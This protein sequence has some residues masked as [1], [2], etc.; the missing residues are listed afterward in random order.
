MSGQAVVTSIIA[1]TH[2]HFP[3]YAEEHPA[4]NVV[5]AHQIADDFP[6]YTRLVRRLIIMYLERVRVVR[7]EICVC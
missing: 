3:L 5:R 7:K 2:P 4:N 6:E 1:H